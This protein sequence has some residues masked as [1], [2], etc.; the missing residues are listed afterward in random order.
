MRKINDP[1]ILRPWVYQLLGC[2]GIS[3][4]AA[5]GMSQ[6]DIQ[7]AIDDAVKARYDIDALKQEIASLKAQ[8]AE[9]DEAMAA[10]LELE[11]LDPRA[12]ALIAKLKK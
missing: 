1:V 3:A 10:E 2:I 6:S 7:T 11:A 5:D 8:L 4:G 9:H 12:K